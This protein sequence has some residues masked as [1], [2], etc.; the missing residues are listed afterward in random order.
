MKRELMIARD[1]FLACVL[2]YGFLA[3]F[4]KLMTYKI[5]Y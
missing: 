2:F 5:L 3:L 1:S 4:T